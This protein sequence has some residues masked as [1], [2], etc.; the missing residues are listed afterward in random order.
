[1]RNTLAAVQ[2]S[3]VAHGRRASALQR[4]CL[5]SG[6]YPTRQRRSSE[7][8]AATEFDPNRKSTAEVLLYC[9]TVATQPKV[10]LDQ[11]DY[12]SGDRRPLVLIAFFAAQTGLS[13][14]WGKKRRAKE[15]HW[16]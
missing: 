11:I 2:E 10:M 5:L 3:G 14:T 12:A 8:P 15:T 16:S 1:M 6:G 4:D 7:P 9:T 13:A